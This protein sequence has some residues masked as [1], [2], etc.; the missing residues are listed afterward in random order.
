MRTSWSLP[1]SMDPV[2]MYQQAF[3]VLREHVDL[4]VDGGT[5]LP[6]AP[7]RARKRLGDEAH[8][9]LVSGDADDGEA[10][11]VQCDRALLHHVTRQPGRDSDDDV[12][13]CRAGGAADD[14]ADAVDMALHQMTAECRRGCRSSL[15][16]DPASLG[17]VT[18]GCAPARLRQQVG[19]K[20]VVV[21]LRGGQADTV[22]GNRVAETDCGR[23]Q[24][25]DG[26]PRG[27]SARLDLHDGAHARNDSGEHQPTSRSTV[28]STRTSSPSCRTSCRCNRKAAPS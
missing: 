21:E 4:H 2:S 10:H 12:V 25:A 23:I 3:D 20:P 5:D 19:H 13:P 27:F 9:Y 26:D 18:E 7:S 17:E 1:F 28:A 16:V 8:R 6:L 22:D 24:A 11:A 14:V 15:Q